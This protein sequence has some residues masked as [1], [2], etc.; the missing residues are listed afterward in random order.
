MKTARIEKDRELRKM[1]KQYNEEVDEMENLLFD[2]QKKLSN[3]EKSAPIGQYWKF[4]KK[5]EYEG[6]I[7]RDNE[8]SQ[9]ITDIENQLEETDI[10]ASV[11]SAKNFARTLL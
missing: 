9:R 7:A 11:L 5:S 3:G 1:E 2:L 4:V 8:L 6:L 10:Q